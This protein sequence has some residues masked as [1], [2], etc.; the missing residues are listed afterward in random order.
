MDILCN[1]IDSFK[2]ATRWFLN[3]E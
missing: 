2:R 1:M 3:F